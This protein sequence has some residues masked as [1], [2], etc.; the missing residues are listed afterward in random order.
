MPW[1]LQ[2]LFACRALLLTPQSSDGHPSHRVR[3]V[4][5]VQPPPQPMSLLRF[6]V[7]WAAHQRAFASSSE[8]GP[9]GTT[10]GREPLFFIGCLAVSKNFPD[11]PQFASDPI[12]LSH[13]IRPATT[14]CN[15]RQVPFEEAAMICPCRTS[16]LRIFV[17]TLTK[18]HVPGTAARAARYPPPRFL[19]A[20]SP[21][22]RSFAAL[23]AARYPRQTWRTSPTRP[24][25][26]L[27]PTSDDS[28]NHC[29]TT[30]F[31]TPALD[32][33]STTGFDKARSNGAILDFSPE[34]ID[35]LAA[36]LRRTPRIPQRGRGVQNNSEPPTLAK[37][38]RPKSIRHARK[39]VSQPPNV[40]IH[41]D[42]VEP[43]PHKKE[44]WQI[45]KASLKEKFPEGWQPRKRLSPDALEGIRALHSQ[46][47][48]EFTTDVLAT[49]F[50]VSPESIRR[51]LKSK[52]VPN[53]EE[54]ES[55]QERWFNRGKRIWTQMAELGTKPPKKWRQ[56]GVVRDPKWNKRKGPRT[57]WPYAPRKRP[58]EKMSTQRK[59]GGNLL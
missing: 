34:A 41:D 38:S 45:Q 55:R 31:D 44:E 22:T 59:L 30:D 29:S 47:P 24:E 16:S 5:T 48:E 23:S 26:H 20:S 9:R 52:W 32:V 4:C 18:I 11:G 46:F 2:S 1:M 39:E 49:K 17:Q 19:G 8:P 14:A 36:D 27:N 10:G 50:E 3:H 7:S 28:S 13:E 57:E 33:T 21:H 54:E 37:P 53:A 6:P 42:H 15:L 25:E 40:Q 43:S 56:E 12:P 58:E 51:I 35:S